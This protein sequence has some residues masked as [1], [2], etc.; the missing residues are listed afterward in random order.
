VSDL[1]T[2]VDQDSITLAIEGITVCSGLSFS[3]ISTVSGSGFRGTWTH[4]DD[5]FRFGSSVSVA[6]EATDLSPLE[7][8]SLFVC[9]FDVEQSNVPEFINFIP[10]PCDTF[11]DNQTGL[12]F[13]VYGDV[14]GVDITTLE[15]RVDNKLRKV[16]VRPRI[17]R[18]E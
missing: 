7:N 16:V 18:S 5:P 17:L 12:T 15:V 3:P 13:E 14:D 9:C 10:E 11:V 4:A 8:S 6:I 2:G 1:G